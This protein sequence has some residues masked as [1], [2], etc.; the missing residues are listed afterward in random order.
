ML[1]YL[2]QFFRFSVCVCPSLLGLVFVCLCVFVC[3]SV[4]LPE[5]ILAGLVSSRGAW[6]EERDQHRS[7]IDLLMLMYL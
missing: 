6:G 3:V 2:K 4:C 1:M 5:A 7:K